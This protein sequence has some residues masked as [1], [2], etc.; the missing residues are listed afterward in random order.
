MGHP[1]IGRAVAGVSA[2]GRHGLVPV[3]RTGQ[4]DR[5]VLGTELRAATHHR[6]LHRQQ[7][8][9]AERAAR[10]RHGASRGRHSR[11]VPGSCGCQLR[12]PGAGRRSARGAVPAGLVLGT[13]T[14]RQPGRRVGADRREG[15]LAARR[16]AGHDDPGRSPGATT[17]FRW[18]APATGP[19]RFSVAD[20]DVSNLLAA[21]SGAGYGSLVQL[22]RTD[23]DFWH[24][25][26]F[27][28][29]AGQTYLVVADTGLTGGQLRVEWSQYADQTKPAGAVVINGGASSTSSRMVS[30]TLSATDNVGVTGVLISNSPTME[31]RDGDAGVQHTLRLAEPLDGSPSTVHW[32][33]TD[34]YRGGNNVGGTK[35]VY[36]QWQ[37][38]QG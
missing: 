10:R 7:P 24:D 30:L 2:A 23:W 11:H 20:T 25:L 14:A 18:T 1:R 12:N 31:D 38:A 4:R 34:L 32:S 5:L 37:D 27:D 17:W 28:A 13:A 9:H 6:G 29:V 21:Y 33:L 36:V 16:L 19:V 35:T 15:S 8:R 3:D 22:A 26:H